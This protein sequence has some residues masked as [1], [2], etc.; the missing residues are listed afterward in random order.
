MGAIGLGAIPDALG[1]SDVDCVPMARGV[2]GSLPLRSGV[3]RAHRPNYLLR[4][5]RISASLPEPLAASA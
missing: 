3:H 1:W 4:M 2:G 5:Q